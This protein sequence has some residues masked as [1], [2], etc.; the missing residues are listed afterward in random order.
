M[1]LPNLFKHTFLGGTNQ[2]Q[3]L[4]F[5]RFTVNCINA[6]QNTKKKQIKYYQLSSTELINRRKLQIL[7]KLLCHLMC[8]KQFVIE[9]SKFEISLSLSNNSK[10]DQNKGKSKS[11]KGLN[12]KKESVSQVFSVKIIR[13]RLNIIVIKKSSSIRLK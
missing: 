5:S 10:N 6:N 11:K 12:V 9:F 8:S 1:E 2:A 3:P 13:L 7:Q 4:H